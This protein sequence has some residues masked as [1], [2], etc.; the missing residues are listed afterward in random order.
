M[1]EEILGAWENTQNPE[2]RVSC[3]Y[4]HIFRVMNSRMTIR[5]GHEGDMGGRDMNAV[6]WW[7]KVKR[8]FGRP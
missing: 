8:S 5:L 7:R 2:I 6:L 3:S 4:I 1:D